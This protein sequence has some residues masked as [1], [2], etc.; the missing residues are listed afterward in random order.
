MVFGKSEHL[1]K[2]DDLE[3]PPFQENHVDVWL[4]ADCEKAGI[5]GSIGIRW[6]PLASVGRM[7]LYSNIYI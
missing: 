4:L 2:V 3:L 1:S 5:V 7:D 6:G